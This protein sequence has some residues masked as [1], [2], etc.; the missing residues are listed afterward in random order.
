M[1]MSTDA[2]EIRAAVCREFGKPLS[3]EFSGR[4]LNLR[5]VIVFP[6]RAAAGA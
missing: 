5:H 4:S 6:D 2:I 3:I 1:A